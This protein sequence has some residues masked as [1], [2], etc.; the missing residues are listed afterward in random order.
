M[1]TAGWFKFLSSQVDGR[2]R[3]I[4]ISKESGKII[5]DELVF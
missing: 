4:V 3:Y 1:K 2:I 5:F